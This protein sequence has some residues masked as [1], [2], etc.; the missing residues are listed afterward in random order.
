MRLQSMRVGTRLTL[1]MLLCLAP[2]ALGY[3]LI[4]AHAA[5]NIFSHELKEETRIAQRALNA[6]LTADVEQREW[7]E[8]RYIISELGSEDLI[9]ALLDEHGKL[10]FA[11]PSFPIEPPPIEW[12]VQQIKTSGSA[13]FMRHSRGHLWFCRIEV[14]GGGGQ[15][16][17]LVAQDWTALNHDRYWRIATSLAAVAGFLLIVATVIPLV[18]R[19]YVSRPLME[20]HRR[21]SSFSAS[22]QDQ[23]GTD[24]V[25]LISNEFGRVDQE[26]ASA[27]RR[28]LEESERKLQ[29]ERRLMQ[30]DKLA[31]I[32]TLASGFAHEIGTP[33]GII[34]GRTELLAGR[35]ADRR[36]A[37][38]LQVILGQIDRI[39]T[40][41]RMLLDL[42]RRRE[43]VRMPVDLRTIVA[44]TMQL[45]ETEAARRRVEVS[46]ELGSTP[47]LVNCDPD[48]LQQ[49][50]VN[51]EINALDAIGDHG[52][53]LHITGAHDQPSGK[54]S[55]RFTD[56][57][58]GVPEQL[59]ERI[60]DP[61]FTTKD[62]G[63][64]TGMGLAVSRS[65]VADHD[66]EL[67]VE[68]SLQGACFAVVLPA[69]RAGELKRVA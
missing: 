49:I 43:S 41:V 58:P 63:K 12:I 56:T 26:L 46:A 55:L 18:S 23:C 29:L 37:D 1:M 13:E 66:G 25:S 8:I 31:T 45:L 39:S 64:G 2:V 5:G 50:F 21:V 57:G 22:G 60:F 9:A 4:T 42:G 19:R 59:K 7:D 34:R 27:R 14:I 35:T 11:L 32:G 3:T 40:M 38:G 36:L 16:Y 54:V 67:A 10:R 69:Y 28:L 6:A 15:G 53:K 68:S 20:L 61:F 62:P 52:G 51:L 65:I 30:T 24:E 47:L 48:Q 33:L 17:L 44:N